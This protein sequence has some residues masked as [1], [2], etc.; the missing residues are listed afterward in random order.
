MPRYIDALHREIDQYN[1]PSIFSSNPVSTIYFGGGTPSLMSPEFYQITLGKLRSRF[2]IE[3]DAEISFEANPGALLEAHLSE[4][5]AGGINRLTIG[6]QSFDDAELKTLSRIHSSDEAKKALYNARRSG[7]TNIGLDLIFGIP[8]QSLDSFHH[9]LQTAIEIRPEHISMYGLTIE[10]GTPL[11][12]A[13]RNHTLT[14][15]DEELERD[16]YLLGMET[17]TNA[18]YEQYE[19]SNFSL[20]GYASRHNQKYWD[21]SPYLGYG[22]SA[23]SYDGNERWWNIA[24]VDEYISRIN[25]NMPAQ[26][27]LESITHQQKLGELIM[28][29]LRRSSG[30]LL[31]QWQQYSNQDLI[32]QA[33]EVIRELGGTDDRTRPF[34]HSSSDQKLVLT[35]HSLALSRQG[36]LVYDTICE[37]FFKII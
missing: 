5:L 1:P 36:L 37:H 20:P 25:K 6:I 7:F 11:D 12:K 13:V 3:P 34:H 32:Q 10:H 15:C 29:G 28:L 17:L 14:P 26:K 23:H 24:D 21:G 8:V 35:P 16:M 30:I 4:F 31:A 9:S 22:P 33:Q 2:T 18:G 27:E 19:I